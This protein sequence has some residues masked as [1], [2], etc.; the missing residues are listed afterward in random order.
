MK[1][2]TE[3]EFNTSLAN[4]LIKYRKL[5]GLTQAELAESINYSDKSISKWESGKGTPGVFQ[6]L[7]ISEIYGISV[8]ELIGQTEPGKATAEKMK[9]AEKDRKAMEKA[10]K[11]ALERAKK[12]KRNR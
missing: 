3:N 8:S 9:A 6:L 4:N 12:Q 10:R 5:N 2:L 11:K 7:V 1:A